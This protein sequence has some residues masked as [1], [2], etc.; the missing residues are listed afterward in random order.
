M[1]KE[2][3]T[4]LLLK[5]DKYLLVWAQIFSKLNNRGEG[6]LFV[7]EITARNKVPNPTL[8]R[9]LDYGLKYYG[10]K[11]DCKWSN[12]TLT[13]SNVNKIGEINKKIKTK[14]K[15]KIETIKPIT[16]IEEIINF[17]NEECGTKY[18]KETKNTQSLIKA[19]LKEGFTV[20][21]IKEVITKK[22][23]EWLGTEMEK[24]LRPQTL[25]G[26]KFES[27]LNQSN[28]INIHSKI[29]NYGKTTKKRSDDFQDA[30]TKADLID[31][32]KIE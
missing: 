16:E 7:Y 13:F 14:Q 5:P 32:S 2:F 4:Y 12:K 22:K 10:V 30:I 19:K 28:Q 26:N 6:V 17:L 27:Y 24:Y 9:I 25:F 15:V 31:Y 20:E 18:K 21:D 23:N 8:K 3:I 11:M 29:S 1:E